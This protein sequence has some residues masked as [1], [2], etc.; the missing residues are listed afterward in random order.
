M[1][2]FPTATFQELGVPLTQSAKWLGNGAGCRLAWNWFVV[3]VASKHRT[4][5]AAACVQRRPEQA[6]VQDGCPAVLVD[7]ASLPYL[8]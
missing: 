8:C 1:Q 2:A 5:H 6:A 4:T 7:G 3:A